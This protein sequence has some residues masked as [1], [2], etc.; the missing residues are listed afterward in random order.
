MR[1]LANRTSPKQPL[2][3]AIG[4]ACL[5]IPYAAGFRGRYPV[6]AAALSVGQ[7]VVLFLVV[8]AIAFPVCYGLRLLGVHMGRWGGREEDTPPPKSDGEMR[9]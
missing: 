5:S 8:F 1:A 4:I 3:A 7:G 9:D 6:Q 2:Y